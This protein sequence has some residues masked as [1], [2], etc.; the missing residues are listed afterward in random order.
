MKN[1]IAH[2]KQNAVVFKS[3]QHKEAT[4]NDKCKLY[5]PLFHPST[6]DVLRA[7]KEQMSFSN[8]Q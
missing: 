1:I 4:T 2:S 3:A 8:K 5:I 6:C 7:K